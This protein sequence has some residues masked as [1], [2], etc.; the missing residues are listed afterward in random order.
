MSGVLALHRLAFAATEERARLVVAT[1][2]E[3]G[4][5]LHAV[6]DAID[7]WLEFHAADVQTVEAS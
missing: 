1:A 2:C 4:A 7:E 5:P 6:R 3:E